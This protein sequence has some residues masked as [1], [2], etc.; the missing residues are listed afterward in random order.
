[1]QHSCTTPAIVD[2]LVFVGDLGRKIYCFDANTGEEYWSHAMKGDVWSSILV[3]DGKVYAG[4][5]GRDFCIFEASRQKRVLAT[6]KLD[7]PMSTTPTAA[8]GV[9]Y[10]NTLTRLYAIRQGN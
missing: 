5:H 10:I 6:V 8:N 3:A 9:L 2:D 4:S 7:S 1:M